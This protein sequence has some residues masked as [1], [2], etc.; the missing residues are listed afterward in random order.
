MPGATITYRIVVT[1]TGSETA[2]NTAITDTIPAN[3]TY[4]PESMSL[5][6]GALT[7]DADTDAG[8]Y[9]ATPAPEIAVDLGDLTETSGVQTIEFQVTID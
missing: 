8:A 1:P 5:N 6:G 4:S 3:T 9:T 2:A 7:D